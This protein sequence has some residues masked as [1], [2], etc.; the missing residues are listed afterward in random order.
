MGKKLTL[1][2]FNFA[3]VKPARL[4]KASKYPLDFLTL[5]IRFFFLITG[6]YLNVRG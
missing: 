3:F 1:H 5:I 6:F 4:K 2:L